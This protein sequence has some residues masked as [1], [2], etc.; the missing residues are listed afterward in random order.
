MKNRMFKDSNLD[1]YIYI[2]LMDN[3][4]SWKLKNFETVNWLK[5]RFK[6]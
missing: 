3:Q 5:N 6:N 1:F 4:V 2:F